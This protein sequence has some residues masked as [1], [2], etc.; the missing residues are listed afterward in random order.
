MS[1]SRSMVAIWLCRPSLI[2]TSTEGYFA[3]KRSSDSVISG[4]TRLRSEPMVTRPRSTRRSASFASCAAD[5]M[6]RA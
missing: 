4:D 5:R 1:R 3:W 2:T 6:R